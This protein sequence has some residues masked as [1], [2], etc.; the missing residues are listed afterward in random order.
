MKKLYLLGIFCLAFGGH[1]FAQPKKNHYSPKPAPVRHKQVAHD[2]HHH[3]HPSQKNCKCHDVTLITERDINC[4]SNQRIQG[5]V[6]DTPGNYKLCENI[7]WAVNR[8][9]SFAITIAADN[10]TLDLDGHYIKQLDPTLGGNFAVQVAGS[11]YSIIQNGIIQECS[12]GAVILQPGSTGALIEG[13]KCNRC[14]Y[15]G[16]TTLILPDLPIPIG[17]WASAIFVNGAPTNAVEDVVIRDCII[18][19]NGILGTAPVSFLGTISGTTLTTEEVPL[20]PLTPGFLL[21]GA[22]VT[23]GTTIVAGSGTSYTVSPSQTVAVAEEMTVLD[24]SGQFVSPNPSL[25]VGVSAI[26]T[27][28]SSNVTVE[29]CI[30]DGHFGYQIAFAVEFF[31]SSDIFASNIH[32]ND[33]ETF[34]LAKAFHSFLSENVLI[35]DSTVSGMTMNVTSFAA[36]APLGSGV[37]GTKVSGG[38][39]VIL[40]RVSYT[41]GTVQT[42][43]PTTLLSPA[44]YLDCVGFVVDGPGAPAINILVEDC[45]TTDMHNDGGQISLNRAYAAGFNIISEA[46][47]IDGLHITGSRASD[48]SAQVGWAFGFGAAPVP[49]AVEN[50]I[51]YTDCSA[52]SISTTDDGVYAAGFIVNSANSQVHNC[53]VQYVTGDE[54]YGII[55]DTATFGG[56][57]TRCVISDNRI[58]NC[59]TTGIID[60]T[61]AKNSVITGN[62]AAL[63]GPGASGNYT[64]LNANVPIVVWS[65]Y[66]TTPAPATPSSLDNLDIRN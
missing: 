20:Y 30:V 61:T 38:N 25:F 43:V 26:F 15:N 16:A 39:N 55:L 64:T 66:L 1:L 10:V 8:P 21:L 45:E 29:N 62:Y 51:T 22:S 7:N 31:F 50:N 2:R 52:K 4:A 3:H 24:Q 57:A 40:R 34:G 58:T 65:P 41:G 18:T 9:S 46:G 48:I 28:F 42:E 44:A 23:S 36:N 37:E 53:I 32:I 60:N 54:A 49:S 6:I 12:G 59:A 14:T 5:Y 47:P 56:E 19:D 35:E 33:V 17:G 27:Y 63:N 11:N 13:L